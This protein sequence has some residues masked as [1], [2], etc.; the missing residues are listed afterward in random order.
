MEFS[1]V[2]RVED[3]TT[4]ENGEDID[5]SGCPLYEY[6]FGRNPARKGLGG[7]GNPKWRKKTLTQDRFERIKNKGGGNPRLKGVRRSTAL[8]RRHFHEKKAIP[9]PVCGE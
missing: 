9:G 5:Y 4:M 7:P 8:P 2:N 6:R 3:R 1:G